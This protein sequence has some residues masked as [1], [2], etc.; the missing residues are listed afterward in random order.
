[1]PWEI[2]LAALAFASSTLLAIAVL[3]AAWQRRSAPGAY[4]LVAMLVAVCAWTIPA[5]IQLFVGAIEID[6]LCSKLVYIGVLGAPV[7]FLVF[8]TQVALPHL[9][10]PPAFYAGFSVPAFVF[11]GLVWTNE[12]HHLIWT[13]ITLAPHSHAYVYGHGP[14]YFAIYGYLLALITGATALYLIAAWRR[15]A[16]FRR[17]AIAPAAGALLPLAVAST[18][19]MGWTPLAGVDFTPGAFALTALAFALS[20][21]R[22]RMLDL[23]PVAKTAVFDRLVDGVVVLDDQRRVL[24]ANASAITLLGPG[25]C[26]VGQAIGEPAATWV[27][28]S[29]VL[30]EQRPGMLS[31]SHLGKT[32]EAHV[33]S[34]PVRRDDEGG[35]ILLLRDI[36]RQREAETAL[37][38]AQQT[39]RERVQELEQA[40]A[41]VRTL[42]DLLP[43]CSYCKRVRTDHDYWQQI[44]SYVSTRSN[45]RFSHGICPD[46]YARVVRDTESPGSPASPTAPSEP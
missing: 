3:L 10:I 38:I 34:I 25:L 26:R 27:S 8:S 45:V 1:M 28:A 36:T 15:P 40:A 41:H 2:W 30:H 6:I 42:Q 32:L 35:V 17:M 23:V 4:A 14:A 24:E 11:L 43:I 39:L 7:L 21:T 13:S 5:T 33:S 29:T 31:A 12:S 18:Y 20:L 9:R 19:A 46:C 16:A 22:Y 44:E 37:M